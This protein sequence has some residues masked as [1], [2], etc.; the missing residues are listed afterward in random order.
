MKCWFHIQVVTEFFLFD[1]FSI[2][3]N[4]DGKLVGADTEY[5]HE[6]HASNNWISTI[7]CYEHW[8]TKGMK[9]HRKAKV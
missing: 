1:R 2:W 8:K 6:N 5:K 4:G 3:E 7:N 9:I